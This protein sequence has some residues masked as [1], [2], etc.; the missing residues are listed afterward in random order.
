MA[1][2]DLLKDC[3]LFLELYDREIEKIVKDCHV[4][5]FERGQTIVAAGHEG[6][7]IYVILDGSVEI[8]KRDDSGSVERLQVLK[9]GDVLGEASLLEERVYRS[10]VVARTTASLLEIPY[11]AF[12]SRFKTE[13]RVFAIVMLNL[14][15]MM[16]RRLR[17]A[18]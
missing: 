7:E 8:Q 3:T 12:F 10:D 4:Y 13:P 11:E 16:A 14:S 2:P 5:T 15:R 18:S 1:I 6:K 17:S 9:K